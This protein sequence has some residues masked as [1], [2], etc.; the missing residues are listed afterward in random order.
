M[1]MGLLLALS[2]LVASPMTA[3]AVYT[4]GTQDGIMWGLIALAIDYGGGNTKVYTTYSE[5]KTGSG[6]VLYDGQAQAVMRIKYVSKVGS[7]AIY[8]IAAAGDGAE[9]WPA[10]SPSA[11]ETYA[12]F[13]FDSDLKMQQ[14]TD[15]SLGDQYEV[16]SDG[17]VLYTLKTP[18]SDFALAPGVILDSKRNVAGMIVGPQLVYTEVFDENA[19]LGTSSRGGSGSS[20]GSGGTGGTGTGTGSTG[21]GSGS[22]GSSSGGNK[23]VL[24][25]ALIVAAGAGGFFWYKKKKQG[26]DPN[27]QQVPGMDMNQQGMGAQQGFGTPRGF[28]AQQPMAGA[29]PGFNPPPEMGQQPGMGFGTPQPMGFDAGAAPG[30]QQPMQPIPP[31]MQAQPATGALFLACQGGYQDGRVYPLNGSM[32]IGRGTNCNIQYPNDYPGISREHAMIQLNA[33]RIYLTDTSSTG[34]YLE[35]TKSK[36]QPR[37]TIEMAPGDVFYLGEWKNKFQI[38]RK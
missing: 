5:D 38:V 23:S 27:A 25:I 17:S 20:G 35:K 22:S 32:L 31:A 26:E 36:M 7:M 16:Q 2:I 11:N 4:A 6:Q 30:M 18:L 3:K 37:Q 21:T 12:V 14:L 10:A 34:I 33:G 9:Y 29:Q 8:D 28:G 24:I 15:V 1:A 13:Y 19:F